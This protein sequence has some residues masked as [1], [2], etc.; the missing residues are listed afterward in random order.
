M[1][2]KSP[3]AVRKKATQKQVKADTI[4]HKKQ[5]AAAAKQVPGKK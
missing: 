4:T 2:D 1:S 3:K 5:E